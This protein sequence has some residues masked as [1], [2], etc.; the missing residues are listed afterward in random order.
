MSHSHPC[1]GEDV[2]TPGS[3][4]GIGAPGVPVRVRCPLAA[5]RRL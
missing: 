3:L 5:A 1:A 2:P 4:V